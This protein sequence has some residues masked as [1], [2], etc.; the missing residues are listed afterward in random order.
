MRLKTTLLILISI[1]TYTTYTF[2][3]TEVDMVMPKTKLRG[4]ALTQSGE[5]VIKDIRVRVWD[6]ETEE[7]VFRTHTNKD[8]IFVIPDM[9]SV[10]GIYY[11]TVGAV[12]VD[13]AVLKSRGPTPQHNGLVIV[14]PDKMPIVSTLRPAST[15]LG[16]PVSILAIQPEVVSP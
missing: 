4:A 7:I 11:V 2:S 6:V 10:A 16:A 12:R 1:F 3:Q 9:R 15:V 5:G 14:M 13:L 8:G